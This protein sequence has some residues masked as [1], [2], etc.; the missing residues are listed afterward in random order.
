MIKREPGDLRQTITHRITQRFF[1][2]W[3]MAAILVCVMLSGVVCSALLLHLGLRSMPWRYL[4]A[5]TGSYLIFFALIR[6]WLL[7][8]SIAGSGRSVPGVGFGD[9]GNLGGGAPDWSSS[10]GPGFRPGGG[11][12]GGGGASGSFDAPEASG[13]AASSGGSWSSGSESGWGLDLDDGW[14]VLVAFALLLLAVTGSGAY[15]IYQ[16]PHILGEAAFQVALAT[17]LRGAAR[18]VVG[19]G[20]TGSLLRSTWISFSIVL[21]MAGIFGGVAQHYCSKASKITEVLFA[22]FLSF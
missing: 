17:S 5:V 12:F 9:L 19:F 1:V 2:R 21:A 3:H 6:L 22:C 4:L 10:S 16:A 7:Y 8:V 14:L 18:R 20:W 15:L 11:S 13:G